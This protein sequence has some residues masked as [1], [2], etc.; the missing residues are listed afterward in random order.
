MNHLQTAREAVSILVGDGV[1]VQ[2]YAFMPD[3]LVPPAAITLPASPYLSSG[4]TFGTFTL[5]LEVVVVVNSKVNETGAN[6]LDGLIVDAVVE[7]VNAGISVSEVSEPWELT[8]STGNYLAATIT[9]NQP[10]RL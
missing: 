7:L 1:D 9:T 10:I 3:R 2:A 6:N 4:E 5:G 8:S